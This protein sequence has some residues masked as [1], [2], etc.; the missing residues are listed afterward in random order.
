MNATIAELTNLANGSAA[1]GDTLAAK[2]CCDAIAEIKRLQGTLHDLEAH[3]G[4]PEVV[5]ENAATQENNR[6][7]MAEVEQLQAEKQAATDLLRNRER[8]C[9]GYSSEHEVKGYFLDGV[10]VGKTL[11][12][13]VR[14]AAESIE[15]R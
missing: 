2:I 12:D 14:K 8:I 6:A 15:G 13:V 11:A 9:W 10:Y 3:G 1:A 7:L 4:I 5:Q